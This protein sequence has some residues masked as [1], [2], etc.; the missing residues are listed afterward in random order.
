MQEGKKDALLG[1]IKTEYGYHI[2]QVQD[3]RE[4]A[5]PS[6]DSMRQHLEEEMQQRKV[7]AFIDAQKAQAKIVLEKSQ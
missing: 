1:P 7:M 3:S 5:P 4:M 2:I 6:L